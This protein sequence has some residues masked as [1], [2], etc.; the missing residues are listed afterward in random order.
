MYE[1]QLLLSHLIINCKSKI[2]L[3]P[4]Y[5]NVQS[6]F[7]L[8]YSHFFSLLDSKQE[9]KWKSIIQELKEKENAGTSIRSAWLMLC[10]LQ[11]SDFKP[12]KKETWRT[13]Q[14]MFKSYAWLDNRITL[15]DYIFFP[16]FRSLLLLPQICLFSVNGVMKI[17][18]SSWAAGWTGF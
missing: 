9:R 6:N 11:I 16:W 2:P 7:T 15:L 4:Q 17:D 1:K 18:L 8:N 13:L 3:A 14:I 12:L 5:A 10:Q